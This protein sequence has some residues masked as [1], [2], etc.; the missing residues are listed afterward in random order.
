MESG[1]QREAKSW[2]MF[3]LSGPKLRPLEVTEKL[4]IQ[5]DYYHGADVKDIENM[6]ISSHW[7][8]NSKLGPEFPVLDHIWNLLK[9]LAPV[10][11]SLK[12]FTES[13]ESTIYVSVEF[14]SEFTKGVVLDKRTMLLLGELGVNLEIIPWD[15]DGTP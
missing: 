2:A 1:T 13:Y 5:P 10:R 11:K 4:G 14:A 12:E 8:L 15:L 9:T 6:T 7:Q 3:A